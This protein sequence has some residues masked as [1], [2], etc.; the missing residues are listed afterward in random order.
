MGEYKDSG[1]VWIGKIPKS[2]KLK[3]IKYITKIPVTDGPHE[4]PIFV[5]DGIPFYSVDGIQDGKIIYEPCRYISVEDADR[6]D[7]KEIPIIGDIL[8][9]KAASIGKIAIIDRKI[10]MQIWS[11][12]AII[13]VNDKIVNN[14]FLKYYLLSDS[15]QIEI[16]LRS[17]TN[18]QKNI[19]MKDIE[20]IYIPIPNLNEQKLIAS[21]LDEK[22]SKIDNIL[23]NLKKQIE[24]LNNYKKS[25][26][27]EVVTKGLDKNVQMK[28]SGIEWVG[29][30]PKKW[31]IS[32]INYIAKINGRIGFKGYSQEDL[33][34]EGAYT[35]GGEHITN[36]AIDLSNPKFISWEKYYE[37]PEIM[38]KKGDIIIAQRGTLGKVAI[39]DKEI[40]K[41]T[42]NPSLAILNNLKIY[43][44][45]LYYFLLSDVNQ[46]EIVLAN[47]TTAIPMISQRQISRFSVII[48]SREE[49]IKIASFLDKECEKIN[50]TLYIKQKQI[51]KL[52]EYKKSLIYE[53]V[54]GKK[55]VKGE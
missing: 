22:T 19:A 7:K 35:I 33:V 3:K 34:E 17:T 15:S 26:I 14:T 5:D 54:T 47:T 41:A 4:T 16:D 51:E 13:R 31:K 11:P 29:K 32:R 2:W 1:I 38:L 45:Y 30:I 27:T 9:G 55:R 10:R 49:Q 37:S 36:N 12:L 46:T 44:R 43:D 53:Y 25:K 40:G 6:F 20:N 52:E 42:I 23:H 8:M 28:E 18:T 21:F 48:P 39:V 24:I 50:E